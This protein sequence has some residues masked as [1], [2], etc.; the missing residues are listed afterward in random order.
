MEEL[1]NSS[2]LCL[3]YMGFINRVGSKSSVLIHLLFIIRLSCLLQGDDFIVHTLE[4]PMHHLYLQSWF[5]KGL[6][7]KLTFS[8]T[9][10][11]WSV[12]VGRCS[13]IFSNFIFI[14][15]PIGLKNSSISTPAQINHHKIA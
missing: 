1:G 15:S 2:S 11:A 3:M 9:R 7:S 6:P 14:G 13:L 8:S 5:P 4:E 10:S 12:T